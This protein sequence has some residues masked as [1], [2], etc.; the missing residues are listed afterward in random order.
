MTTDDLLRYSI[1]GAN[2]VALSD[3]LAKKIKKHFAGERQNRFQTFLLAAGIR[4]RYLL[5]NGDKE[6]YDKAF[7]DW[8]RKNEMGKLFG[9]LPNFTRYALSGEVVAHVATSTTNPRRYL[10][11]LP[12]SMSALYAVSQLLQRDKDMI[13]AC[14]NTHPT[15][16]SL[17]QPRSE[18]GANGE[19]PLIHPHVTQSDIEFFMERWFNP[20]A[21]AKSAPIQ[22]K[23]MVLLARLYVS[24]DLFRFDEKTGK[25][26]GGI[27]LP[28]VQKILASLQGTLTKTAG[29]ALQEQSEKIK[30]QYYRSLRRSGPA[31][32]IAAQ[33][34]QR[35]SKGKRKSA[36]KAVKK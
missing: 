15:R 12:L 29:L 28:E 32:K 19:D 7:S 21:S 23:D 5:K 9:Q 25:H 18:W 22:K 14:L 8:Y 11:Q 17:T 10:D 33:P 13:Q 20:R 2:S 16:K 30:K 35:I 24:K 26:L 1:P 4:R 31:R 6:Q 34:S 36:A 3:A 27:D